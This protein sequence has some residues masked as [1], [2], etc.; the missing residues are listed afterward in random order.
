[1]SLVEEDS[2]ENAESSLD[3]FKENDILFGA[4]RTYFH[5]VLIAP[6]DGI[7]RKTCFILSPK[8]ETYRWFGYMLLYQN[9][10]ID[11]S[12]VVSV[13]ST[14]PYVRWKDLARMNIFIPPKNIIT[15]FNK[16]IEPIIHRIKEN[17][18]LNLNLAKQRDALLPRLM[19]GKMSLEGKEIV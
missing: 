12:S 13:G 19:S 18:F 7:T 15:D 3:T 1:M 2:I 16:I 17:Y 11:Y 6:F 9:S 4:M 8:D 10:T 14:M 5:K